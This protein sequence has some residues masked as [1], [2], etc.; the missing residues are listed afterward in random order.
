V[1]YCLLII[2]FILQ[3]SIVF[4]QGGTLFG[5]VRDSADQTVI[6]G[7]MVVLTNMADTLHNT[8]AASNLKGYFIFKNIKPGQYRLKISYLGYK[9]LFIPVKVDKAEINLGTLYLKPDS[10]TLDEIVVEGQIPP[11]Q[12]HGDTLQYNA[13]AFKTNPDAELEDLLYKLPGI[14]LDNGTIKAHGEEIQQ[15][16]L[17]SKPYFGGDLNSALK[18]IPAETIDKIKIYY[19]QSDMARF[20]GVDDGLSIKVIDIITKKDKRNGQFGK[21]MAG[22]SS[23]NLYR[24]DGNINFFNG[25]RRI[26]LTGSSSDA[27][28][29][30]LGGVSTANSA[31]INYGDSITRGMYLSGSYSW[32]QSFSKT[33]S[34]LQRTY[35][36]T[37]NS[38]SENDAASNNSASHGLNLRLNYNPDSSNY[39][40]FSPYINIPAQNSTSSMISENSANGSLQSKSNHSYTNETGG[41]S[42]SGSLMYGHRFHKPGRTISFN[43]N[44]SVNSNSGSGYLK[45]SSIFYGSHDSLSILSQQNSL[46]SNTVSWSPS[47]NFTEPLNKKTLV[48]FS[49]SFASINSSSNR[50]SY[51][52]DSINKDFPD[53]DTSLSS[54]FSTAALTHRAGISYRLNGKKYYFNAGLN[55]QNSAL[56]GQQ[57]YPYPFSIHR[58]FNNFLPSAMFNY[59]F[60]NTSNINISYQSSAQ[61][62]SIFQLQDIVNNA[63]PLQLSAGNPALKQQYLQ[64]ASIRYG[65]PVS[66][67][68][69]LYFNVS[70]SI[71]MHSISSATIVAGTD[72]MIAG[73]YLM[74][75]GARLTLPVN[76]DGAGSIRG[77]A[78]YTMRLEKIKSNLNLTAGYAYN[79]SPGMM[80]YVITFTRTSSINGGISLGGNIKEHLDYSM[81]FNPNYNIANNNFLPMQN[82]AYFSQ[83]TMFRVNWIAW[84][85]IV[86]NTDLNYHSYSGYNSSFNQNHTSWNAGIG[87]KFFKKQNGEVRLYV[88]DILNQGNTLSRT[89]TDLYIQDRQAN[90]LTRYYMLTF[91]YQLR[92]YTR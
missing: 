46:N 48:Q 9:T 38:Y 78:T 58:N 17:D 23:N 82:T 26:T 74:H 84:K 57:V 65:L 77:T 50:L 28:T 5:Q 59:K 12:Q 92:N 7:A 51:N 75:K 39:M 40:V 19:R 36:G 42:Y 34:S 85:G 68:N 32:N 61:L 52:F 63:N 73:G 53:I 20:T 24:L 55:Y 88:Y 43:I 14:T 69:T 35:L 47:I 10:G 25:N 1:K 6:T 87:K 4:A 60:S 83:N 30:P 37:N 89:V 11:V 66:A 81:A 2:I 90:V 22:A 16:L 54:R 18:N 62:P 45:S 76:L 79:I 64:T 56:D 80:N 13:D 86:I 33:Q 72:S 49:Y 44:A 29:G 41:Y 21:A 3:T 31:G 67:K 71:T 8:G 15:I 70:G 91:I 27:N